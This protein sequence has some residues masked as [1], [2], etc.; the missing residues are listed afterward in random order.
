MRLYHSFLALGILGAVVS[1]GDADG[2]SSGTSSNPFLPNNGGSV[3]GTNGNGTGISG[4]GT[5]SLG[6]GTGTTGFGGSNGSVTNNGSGNA[7][8]GS[9][10]N[11]SNSAGGSGNTNCS[12]KHVEAFALAADVMIVLD[13][14]S[15]MIGVSG[16]AAQLFSGPNRWQPTTQALNALVSDFGE[17]IAFGL[18]V[19]PGTT[20][21]VFGGGG[22]CT[23]GSVVAPP[24]LDNA[25]QI[26]GQIQQATPGGI[27]NVGLTPTS[28][29]L[30]AA[31]QTLGDRNFSPDA[32]KTPAY[33]ILVTDGQPSCDGLGT[34]TQPDIDAAVSAIGELN[35]A[36]IPT[37][38]LGYDIATV[39]GADGFNPS[40]TM[41]QFAQAGGTEQYFEVGN[42]AFESTIR[43]IAAQAVSC[44][45]DLNEVPPDL[46]YVLVTIDGQQINLNDPTL[47]GWHIEGSTIHLQDGAC[48]AIKDG[49]RHDIQVRIV[50]DVVVPI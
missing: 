18:T 49:R 15:S 43:D 40:A 24:A 36:N 37:Y 8:N 1:C 46:D 47:A 11:G 2:G 27:L 44:S 32:P 35:A 6:N 41:N 34:T 38:V 30:A 31:L 45:F 26:T 9:G 10:N 50:C 7:N 3:G 4:N 12:I 23:P 16:D 19:F 17:L 28:T 39:A 20:G 13:R 29:G 48:N 25:G 21:G 42:G 5:G 14:S 33:V 22:Q